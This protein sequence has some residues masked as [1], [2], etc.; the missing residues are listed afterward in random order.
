MQMRNMQTMKI[1]NGALFISAS[2][3]SPSTSPTDTCLPTFFGGVW[4]SVNE[5][6][7]NATDS[8]PAR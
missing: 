4:G 6:S 5:N 8:P 7:P 3:S 2:A 1:A